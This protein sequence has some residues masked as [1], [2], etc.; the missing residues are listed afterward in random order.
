MFRDPRLSPS[1]QVACATCHSPDHA[2][3]PPNALP[4]QHAGGDTRQ[5]GLRATPSLRYLQAVPQFTEHFFE[6]EDEADESVD[7]GATGGLT[8]DGRNAALSPTEARGL[9]LFEAEDKG[10]CASCHFS[11]PGA[12]GSAPQFSDYGQIALGLPRNAAIP[13]NADSGYFDLG[14]CGPLRKGGA[15]QHTLDNGNSTPAPNFQYHHQPLN[16]YASFAPGTAA[17]AAHLRDG[18]LDGASFLKVIDDGKLPQVAFYKPQGNLNEHSGYADITAG[19]AHIA[20]VIAHLEKSP[21]WEHMLVVVT[22]DEN[23]GLWDHVAP[24][25]GD[26]WG[27]GT[28][29]R[30]SS[31]RRSRRR[32]S[33]TTRRRHHLD[34]AVHH[35]PLRAAGAARDR[36]ARQGDRRQRRAAAR[37]SHRR[38]DLGTQG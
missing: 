19:D 14:L 23:G 28:R 16:Y 13:A 33:S 38:A 20:D 34:P 21:Q 29:S 25:K 31:S 11:A 1:G 4:V 30:R 17:R 5:P 15:F 9:A 3:G 18:G 35:Q 32:A 22:Y 6:S 24:P 12:D 2:F 7:N 26:R 36:G 27:P 10:N 8:W 37:R